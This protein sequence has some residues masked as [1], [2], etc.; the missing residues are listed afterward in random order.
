MPSGFYIIIAGDRF[1]P[2]G[3]LQSRPAPELPWEVVVP[4]PSQPTHAR[5]LELYDILTGPFPLDFAV[6]LDHFL[7]YFSGELRRALD[8]PGVE[9]RNLHLYDEP[10][11]GVTSEFS[12]SNQQ[13]KSILEFG[14][15]VTFATSGADAKDWTTGSRILHR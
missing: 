2:E 1:D 13:L 12:F 6:E 10:R 8:A 14:W 5:R 15:D 4:S 3:F 9:C 11:P 7:E